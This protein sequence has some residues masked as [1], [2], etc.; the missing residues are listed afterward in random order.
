MA[1]RFGTGV[2]WWLALAALGLVALRAAAATPTELHIAG[3]LSEGTESAWER[4]VVESMGRV[5]A[6]R[7]HGL[8]IDVQYTE[9]V[10]DDEAE[11]VIRS[12]AETGRFQIIFGDSSYADAVEKVKDEFPEI[13]FA[14]AGSGN[15]PLGGNGYWVYAH[16]HEPAWLMGVLAGGLTRSNVIGVVGT[17]PSE[18][19]NDQINAFLAGARSVNAA[20]KAR[21]SFIDSW[22]DPPKSQAATEAE[23]AAGADYVF[24]VVPVFEA[25]TARKIGCFGNYADLAGLAPDAV[26]TS[27]LIRWDPQI[28]WLIDQWWAHAA[29]GKPYDAPRAARWFTMAEGGAD[30]A[31]YHAWAD[32]VPAALRQKVAALREEILSGRRTIPLVVTPPP[33]D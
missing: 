16:A 19:S 17:Y 29:E 11:Q 25:C 3:V 6:A 4:A 24:E 12:Y 1:R 23:A 33:A 28:A 32:R 10:G 9:R 18:D 21:V 8:A 27:A 20:V 2:G 30:L 31:P 15:K 26:V 5:I 7:P 14:Y 22:Y 13:L